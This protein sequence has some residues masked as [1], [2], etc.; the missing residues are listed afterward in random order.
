MSE[1]PSGPWVQVFI[2]SSS[3]GNTLTSPSLL[4]FSTLWVCPPL[5]A[6]ALHYS[7]VRVQNQLLGWGVGDDANM[8]IICSYHCCWVCVY[9]SRLRFPTQTHAGWM[10]AW[11]KPD[12]HTVTR[13][14]I[15]PVC[16]SDI[17]NR[18]DAIC[19]WGFHHPPTH[20]HTNRHG[21][22]HHHTHTPSFTTHK[23][24]AASWPQTAATSVQRR[25]RKGDLFS[26]SPAL[27]QLPGH[28]V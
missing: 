11:Q 15:Q 6:V 9:C 25:W 27:P 23:H 13:W 2:I 1:S 28:H 8:A 21:G 16:S 10:N 7:A 4:W 17:Q 5:S 3:E 18:E 12:V 24:T 14:Q 19:G 22:G 20:Q 26:S